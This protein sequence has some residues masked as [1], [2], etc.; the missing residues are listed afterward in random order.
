MFLVRN[1]LQYLFYI[2]R[3]IKRF[4]VQRNYFVILFFVIIFEIILF[5]SIGARNLN[6][7]LQ[8][9]DRETEEQ[10]NAR[11]CLTYIRTHTHTPFSLSYVLI[12]YLH[13][14]RFCT[15]HRRV[16]T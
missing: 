4:Y 13:H 10:K 3:V 9:Y 2:L 11:F 16:H 6:D 15:T 8:L 12:N 5:I 1:Y 14:Q 7:C